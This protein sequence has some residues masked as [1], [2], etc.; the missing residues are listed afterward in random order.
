MKIY[1]QIALQEKKTPQQYYTMMVVVPR[2]VLLVHRIYCNLEQIRQE[3]VV[4]VR[5]RREDLIDPIY[6]LHHGRLE[7][8]WVC[9]EAL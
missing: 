6:S 5:N 9:D 3:S 8:H 1:G 7:H 2:T 4:V